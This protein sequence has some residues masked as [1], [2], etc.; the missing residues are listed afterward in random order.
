[1]DIIVT[2]GLGFIGK[3]FCLEMAHRFQKKYI[4]DKLTY[5][6]DLDF[7]YEKLK[8]I[9]WELIVADVCEID[10][11]FRPSVKSA[12]VINFAAESHVDESFEN[13]DKFIM[14]NALGTQKVIDFCIKND[15]KL[16][17]ISTDE[18]Y[19]EQVSKAVDEKQL[20]NPT[21]PYAASKAAADLF[22]QTYITCFQLS[23]KI[24]RANNIFGPRQLA[25]K[26]IPKAI[27]SASKNE[28]FRLHGSKEIRRHFL[29]TTDFNRAI[30]VILNSWNIDKNLIYNISSDSDISI[31]DLVTKIYEY[32]EA[33]PMLVVSGKDRPFNDSNYSIDD[34]KLRSLGWSPQKDFWEEIH[35]LCS[36][37]SF[38]TN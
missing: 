35:K 18:V 32:M 19:G 29:H 20:F 26:V 10:Q 23:A 38:I 2:G 5:A 13:V 14:S 17:H 6:S 7:Y 27:V 12:V 28:V 1:M 36:D 33:D 8:E 34:S 16:L 30:L 37:K 15:H 11:A 25:E 3:N 31:K 24:V 9:G 21:N 22:V 4:I